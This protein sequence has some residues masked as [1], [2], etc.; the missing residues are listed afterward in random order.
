MT[1]SDERT[2]QYVELVKQTV[3][4]RL[5]CLIDSGARL[6]EVKAIT[7]RFSEAVKRAYDDAILDL[8]KQLEGGE[9]DD[10]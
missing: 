5:D 1:D 2:A 7:Q 4:Q 8:I 3:R 9:N 6:A 10:S